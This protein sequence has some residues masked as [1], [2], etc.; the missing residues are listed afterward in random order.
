VA[1]GHVPIGVSGQSEDRT[2]AGSAGQAKAVIQISG[3]NFPIC[4][5]QCSVSGSTEIQIARRKPD[6]GSS[7]SMVS[8]VAANSTQ[9]APELNQ[10]RML[11]SDSLQAAKEF[12]TDFEK[13][14]TQSINILLGC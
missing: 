9:V 11:P 6:I 1:F 2:F 3:S 5:R 12:F 8:C 10:Q 13:A 7:S 4:G 14:V